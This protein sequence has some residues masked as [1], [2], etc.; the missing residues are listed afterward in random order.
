[1]RLRRLGTYI[2]GLGAGDVAVTWL[3]HDSSQSELLFLGKDGYSRQ[4]GL[5][6]VLGCHCDRLLGVNVKSGFGSG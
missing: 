4:V 5:L 2:L 6:L 1:M 3:A